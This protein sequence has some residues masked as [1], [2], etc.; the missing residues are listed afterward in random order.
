MYETIFA[1]PNKNGKFT[2]TD[3]N[4]DEAQEGYEYNTRD[5]AIEAAKQLWPANSAWEGRKVRNGW[6]IKVD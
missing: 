2:L 3:S 5:E 4:G 1:T 6:R